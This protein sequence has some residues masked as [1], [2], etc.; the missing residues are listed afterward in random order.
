[1]INSLVKTNRRGGG[2]SARK[3]ARAAATGNEAIRPGLPG[4]RYRPLSDTD[5]A[6][7][8]DAAL[9]ILARTG[10]GALCI[11]RSVSGFMTQMSKNE[12]WSFTFLKNE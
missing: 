7:V 4:G 5:M 9:A 3:A 2:R 12:L 6:R 10:L 11:S 8:H 1:M